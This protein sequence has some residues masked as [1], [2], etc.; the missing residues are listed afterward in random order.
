MKKEHYLLDILSEDKNGLVSIIA[1]MLNRKLIGIESIC[2]SRTDVHA[3][4]QISIEVIMNP[5]EVSRILHKIKN[6]IEV[7]QAEATLIKEAW[8]QKVALFTLEK[9]ALTLDLFHRLQKYGAVMVG[10]Y[11]DEIV[12]QKT[13]R[14]EDIQALYNE[15]D[16]KHLKS[17][18]KSAAIS[19]KPLSEDESSVISRAA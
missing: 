12:V 4:V 10:Y 17:F 13:G 15:L 18:S 3:Q 1:G 14:E 19:L 9:D 8:Y 16:G 7:Y 6:I 11:A 2:T 5:E